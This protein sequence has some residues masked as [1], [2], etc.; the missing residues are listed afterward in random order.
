M[1]YQNLSENYS[2]I[3]IKFRNHRRVFFTNWMEPS[4]L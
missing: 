3:P 1:R 4:N 2:V